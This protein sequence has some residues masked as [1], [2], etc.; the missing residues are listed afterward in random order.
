MID[1]KRSKEHLTGVNL[2]KKVVMALNEHSG[3][4]VDDKIQSILL[5]EATSLKSSVADCP[6]KD[7]RRDE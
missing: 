2:L 4:R 5:A 1:T 6:H 3:E 7:T